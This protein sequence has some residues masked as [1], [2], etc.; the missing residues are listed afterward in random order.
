MAVVEERLAQ[1]RPI[2]E[3]VSYLNDHGYKTRTG[4]PWTLA[5]LQA[6]MK[7]HGLSRGGKE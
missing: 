6:E 5:I 2:Q 3:T 4:R 7:K 1:S